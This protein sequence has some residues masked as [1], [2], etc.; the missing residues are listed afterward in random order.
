MMDDFMQRRVTLISRAVYW[1][2]I[3]A[4]AN[5]TGCS[6]GSKPDSIFEHA[7]TGAYDA[8]ITYDGTRH[9]FYG[10]SWDLCDIK[11]QASLSLGAK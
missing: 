5:L 6:G 4:F 11:R 2:G 1:V 8:T 9:R 7:A 10:Q 3:I